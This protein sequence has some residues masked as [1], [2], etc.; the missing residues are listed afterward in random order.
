MKRIAIFA[1]GA[2][3]NAEQLILRF[4]KS[5]SIQVALVVSNKPLAGVVSIAQEHQIETLLIEKEN[6]FRGDSYVPVLNRL[7]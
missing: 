6:F 5:S 1:S 4:K 3:S 2:G 7:S